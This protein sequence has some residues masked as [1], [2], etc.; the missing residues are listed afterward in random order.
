MK[1]FGL[2]SELNGLLHNSS[3]ISATSLIQLVRKWMEKILTQ[4]VN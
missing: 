4:S 1:Q 3:A 2:L